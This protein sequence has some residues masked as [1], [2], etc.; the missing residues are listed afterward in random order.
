MIRREVL[1]GG[2]SLAAAAAGPAG[3][4]DADVL[5][6]PDDLAAR[7]EALRGDPA[8]EIRRVGASARGRPIELISLGAGQR[9]ALVVGCPHPNEPVGCLTIEALISRLRREPAAGLGFRWH[10]IRAIDPDGLAMNGAWLKGPR[11]PDAY[12]AGFFRPA[13]DRQPEYSFPLA[14]GSYGF[15]RTT[16]ENA[17]WRRALELTRPV[18]QASLHN[19]D[20]GGAFYL[21]S[22]PMPALAAA[23]ARQPGEAGLTLNPVGEPFADMAPWL[24]GVFPVPDIAA[25]ARAGGWSAGDSSAGYAA[26]RYGTFSLVNEVPFWDDPRLRDG[27]PSG[28]TLKDV[29]LAVHGWNVEIAAVLAAS[30]PR[31]EARGAEAE[32]LAAALDEALAA[33]RRQ[34]ARLEQMAKAPALARP[35][36]VREL[37]V[38]Q[39]LLRLVA[40]R[41]FAMLGRLAALAAPA[42][43]ASSAGAVARA[44]LGQ[45]LKELHAEA[46]LRT[47]PLATLVELQSRAILTAAAALA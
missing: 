25:A 21:L 35:L 12:F 26:A 7:T 41:P 46:K 28:R 4:A 38:N 23:L 19:A 33:A 6:T 3:A 36:A 27:A 31:L 39:T 16:P 30:L 10:F 40:L 17:A 11:T 1:G 24:P 42:P 2:L 43:A 44:H 45:G 15:D 13:F 9:S 32:A 29:V 22:R 47:V 20:Y 8:I 37:A 34:N 18:L 14:A 5:P